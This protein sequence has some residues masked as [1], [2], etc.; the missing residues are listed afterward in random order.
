MVKLVFREEKRTQTSVYSNNSVYVCN[1]DRYHY[2]VAQR[3]ATM[4]SIGSCM[5]CV[6][7]TDA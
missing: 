7:Q 6:R 4:T 1:A 2:L 3:E 5:L